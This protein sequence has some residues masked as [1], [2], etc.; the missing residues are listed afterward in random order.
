MGIE[1]KSKSLT[2]VNTAKNLTHTH[3]HNPMALSRMTV[4]LVLGALM[5]CLLL[6]K[7]TEANDS[8]P[9]YA[10]IHAVRH[11]GKHCDGGQANNGDQCR[12]DD[13]KNV[14]VDDD[15]DDTYKVVNKMSVS[16]TTSAGQSMDPLDVEDLENHVT[17]L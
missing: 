2:H 16:F 5:V 14:D 8:E 3:T 11:D 9:N 1:A 10:P 4:R 6:M 15:V 17:V 12:E 13:N 7:V